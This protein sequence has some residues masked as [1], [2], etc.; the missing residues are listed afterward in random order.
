MRSRA[1]SGQAG[2]ADEEKAKAFDR[3]VLKKNLRSDGMVDTFLHSIVEDD[4][5]E[6][7]EKNINWLTD[8]VQ[9]L[10]NRKSSPSTYSP[11]DR[12]S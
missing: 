2:G 12:S 11:P 9:K 7:K 3:L 6:G 5:R 4:S 10:L 8:R 1:P